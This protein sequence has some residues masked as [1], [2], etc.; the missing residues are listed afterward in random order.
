MPSHPLS[1]IRS[2]LSEIVFNQFALRGEKK[3]CVFVIIRDEVLIS[4]YVI[5]HVNA[6]LMTSDR[7]V[8]LALASFRV[9]EGKKTERVSG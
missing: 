5:I 2:E 3:K 9:V 7:E 1:R 6:F 4:N 8:E